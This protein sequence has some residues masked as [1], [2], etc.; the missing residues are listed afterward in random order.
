MTK[1]EKIPP[2]L[3]EARRKAEKI[4]NDQK[5]LNTFLDEA[6]RKLKRDRTRLRRFLTD[7][8]LLIMMAKAYHKGTYRRIPL[9]SLAMIV[10]AIIYFV[11]PFDIIPDFIAGLGF[12]DDAAV[13]GFV[14]RALSKE[15]ERFYIYLK[16]HPESIKDSDPEAIDL[17]SAEAK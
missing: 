5:K 14:I 12:L 7:I 3:R 11:N 15:I 13:I 17:P 16:D 8:E 4:V 2:G 10:G 6:T 1:T 9:K